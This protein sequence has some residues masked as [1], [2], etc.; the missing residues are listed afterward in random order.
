MNDISDRELLLL[1]EDDDNHAEL[2]EFSLDECDQ[3][4][5]LYRARDGEEAL[6]YLLGEHGDGK[7]RRPTLVFLDL[8]LPKVN[9]IEVLSR[10][11]SHESLRSVPIVILSTSASSKDCQ[12]AYAN[13]ANAYLTKPTD[14]D[15]F[16]AMVRSAWM[17]WGRWNVS[18]A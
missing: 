6:D 11:K 2:I 13:H 16:T 8:N 15:D 7:E 17:F 14:F 3:P 9:G 1:V 18:S 10:V 12:R 4:P 5:S